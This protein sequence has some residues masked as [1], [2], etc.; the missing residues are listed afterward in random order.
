MIRRPPRSTLFPYTT[1]FRSHLSGPALVYATLAGLA[2]P[3]L[4]G[5]FW[6]GET[7]AT[8][9]LAAGG[10][11]WVLLF[12][13]W[14]I[15]RRARP[16]FAAAYEQEDLVEVLEAATARRRG[17]LWFLYRVGPSGLKRA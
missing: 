6:S 17:A 7:L 12:P 14:Y 5:S 13:L 10:V 15:D 9:L 4:A 11:A 16:L 8:K 1:L 2:V 3:L